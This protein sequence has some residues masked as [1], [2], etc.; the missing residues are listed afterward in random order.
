MLIIDSKAGI[1]IGNGKIGRA[2]RDRFINEITRESDLRGVDRD[3]G[4]R[5]KSIDIGSRAKVVAGISF[6]YVAVNSFGVVFDND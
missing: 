2:G 5:I 1:G 6:S 3:A 4:Q